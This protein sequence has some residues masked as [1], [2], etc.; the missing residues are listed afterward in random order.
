MPEDGTGS[1]HDYA[2][3]YNMILYPNF[4]NLSAKN[5]S[6]FINSTKNS[7]AGENG[8]GTIDYNNTSEKSK[9][10]LEAEIKL[11]VLKKNL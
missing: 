9:E 10:Y 2:V 7:M 4:L 8:T 6:N 11:L 5:Q 1:A 3:K